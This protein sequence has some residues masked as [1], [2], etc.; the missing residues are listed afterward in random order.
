MRGL[1]FII[2]ALL[3]TLSS[4]A[5]STD[6]NPFAKYRFTRFDITETSWEHLSLIYQI[7]DSKGRS[8]DV[9]ASRLTYS[10]NDINGDE[11]ASGTGN[12]ITINDF[13]LESEEDYSL[14][15][16][17]MVHPNDIITRTIHR[18]ASPKKLVI[19]QKTSSMSYMI[20]RPNLKYPARTEFVRVNP[21]AMNIDVSYTVCQQHVAEPVSTGHALLNGK[22]SLKKFTQLIRDYE[23]SGQTVKLVFTPSLK[24]HRAL[25]KYAQSSFEA[26]MKGVSELSL[27]EATAEK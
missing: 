20:V 1:L 14:T 8:I 7:T 10:V 5:G 18:K 11:I 21:E 6:D 13:T 2:S 25:L 24:S 19:K 9:P 23:V 17:A 15:V 26:H 16:T 12:F 4:S 3:L 22:E 27:D